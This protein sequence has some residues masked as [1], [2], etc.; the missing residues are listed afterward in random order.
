MS[1]AFPSSLLTK[2]ADS[3]IVLNENLARSE[4]LFTRKRQVTT[5]SGGT[6]DRWEGVLSLIPLVTST[7][8][9]T[10]WAW[11]V[12]VG[13]YGEF[14][15][16]DPDYSG[17]I[18]GATTGLVQGAGQTGTSLIVDGVAAGT[19]I[20]RAGE[21]F[22]VR[23]EMKVA[24]A[25]CTS[26][27]SGVV[28]LTFKPALRVS[29]ADNDPVDFASPEFLFQLTS[30]PDRPTDNQKIWVPTISFEESLVTS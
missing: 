7:D 22:Q 1:T 8:R 12:S 16:G 17:P 26:N 13:L 29:P 18:S 6:A 14:T 27:G 25:N 4:S 19:T 5:L 11:L 15:V 10:F 2:I 21:W 24:T 28:T 30:M 3:R 9:L 23:S 20:L